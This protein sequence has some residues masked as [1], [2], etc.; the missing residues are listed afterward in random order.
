MTGSAHRA[1]NTSSQRGC[2]VAAARKDWNQDRKG[3]GAD[4]AADAGVGTAVPLYTEQRIA[5][6]RVR[7]K[8][9]RKVGIT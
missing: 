1:R 5:G 8:V 4:S 9:V 7:E 2:G 3:N 6:W